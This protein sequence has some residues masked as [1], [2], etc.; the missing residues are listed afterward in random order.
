MPLTLTLTE[1]V[2]PKGS[3]KAAFQMLCQAMLSCHGLQGNQVMTPNVVGSIQLL[4]REHSFSGMA[5]SEV[6]FVEWKVPSFAFATP[7][8][9]R[10]YIAE[11]TQ[12]VQDFSQGRLPKERIWINVTYAVDGAWGIAGQALTNADLADAISKG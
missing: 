9:R 3:E 7:E 1:G 10:G 11:A 5:E 12:I 2:L 6:A 4:P 8:I